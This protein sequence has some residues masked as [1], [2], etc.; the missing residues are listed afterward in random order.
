M[1]DLELGGQQGV[2]GL[3]PGQ[4]RVVFDNSPQ[5]PF[6]DLKLVLSGGPRAL[7]VSPQTCG[8]AGASSE[9]TGWNGAV[10]TP[11]SNVLSTSSGCTQGFSPAFTA[12]TTDKQAGAYSPFTLT[13]GREDGSQRL[14]SDRC[15]HAAGVPRQHRQRHD[16]PKL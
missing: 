11:A 10:A 4:V 2:S 1:A 16:L 3:Q 7:F 13:I 15:D 6:S 14:G 5:L 8:S 12:G 9:I